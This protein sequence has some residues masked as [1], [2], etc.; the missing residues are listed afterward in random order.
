MTRSFALSALSVAL[1]F[2]TPPSTSAQAPV[3]VTLVG[4]NDFHGNL[5]PRDV[6]VG[7]GADSRITQIGGAEALAAYVSAVRDENR[8]GTILL[9]AGD[10][11]QGTFL[12]NRFQGR[13]VVAAYNALE[14]AATTFGNHEFDFGGSNKGH[15]FDDLVRPARSVPPSDL[16]NVAQGSTRE[17]M[18]E[19]RFPYL[20]VN[21]VSQGR[22]E[23]LG[24][25]A[26]ES[27]KNAKC[28]SR[29][30]IFELPTGARIGVLGATTPNTPNEADKAMLAGLEF[31]PLKE[32]VQA[33]VRRLRLPADGSPGAHLVVLITHAGG[34]CKL[35]QD[36]TFAPVQPQ[37]GD[38][39]GVC[40]DNEI[41]ALL[42]ALPL[43]DRPD[44]ILAGHVHTVQRHFIQGIPVVQTF[45]FASSF[46]RI[47]F[48]LNL[49]APSTAPRA[50]RVIGLPQIAEPTYLCHEHF[51]NYRSCNDKQAKL[52]RPFPNAL[53]APIPPT[54]KGKPIVIDG[55]SAPKLVHDVKEALRPFREK[56]DPFA[57]RDVMPSAFPLVS[58]RSAESAMNNC[59]ADA[60]LHQAHAAVLADRAARRL[61]PPSRINYVSLSHSGGIRA[62]LPG[63]RRS[64]GQVMVLNFGQLFEVFPFGSRMALATLTASEL[65]EFGVSLG[66]SSKNIAVISAGWKVKLK[67][68]ETFA[69]TRH[70]SF[71]RPDGQTVTPADPTMYTIVTDEFNL[72]NPAIAAAKASGRTT[73]LPVTKL[74]ALMNG[75]RT[76]P[77]SCRGRAPLDRTIL[78]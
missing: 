50:Q 19:A 7:N 29:S 39:P 42:A 55:P 44:A 14:V 74:D 60:Q 24:F 70:I 5:D 30:C 2:A 27:P 51:A 48:R 71:I 65:Q 21:V 35:I 76:P 41:S 15:E 56:S 40:A 49:Q 57:K 46:S 4:L 1:L 10:A 16:A 64:N 3:Q 17:L 69:P 28:T 52:E 26:I 61:D 8:D 72:Q 75:M 68:D 20:S 67:K 9:D 6:P 73:V 62:S 36:R 78:E 32:R 22:Q 59:T 33:E 23:L 34:T 11:Y 58:D 53:G 66:T 43:E 38:A 13:S 47:D 63:G 77:I 12:S 45:G 54:Y 18:R 31:L 37:A 25:P